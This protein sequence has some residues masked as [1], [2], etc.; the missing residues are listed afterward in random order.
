MK[1]FLGIDWTKDK[2]N[3]KINGNEFLVAALSED[4]AEDYENYSSEFEKTMKNSKLPMGLRV[5]QMICG[6]MA[7]IVFVGILRA[8]GGEDGLTL[9][10]AYESAAW[11]FWI[12]GACL[13]AWGILKYLSVRKEKT[14]MED[15]KEANVFSNFD[16]TCEAAFSELSVPDDAKEVDVLSFFYKVKENDIKLCQMAMQTC[17]YFN[18][19]FKAFS[20]EENLY[21]V[22]LDGKYAFPLSSLVAIRTVKVGITMSNWNKDTYFKE[23]IYKQYKIFCDGYERIHCKNYHILEVMHEGKLWGIYFPSYE[24]PAFE[25]LTGLKATNNK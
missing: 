4:T 15:A 7:A 11:V 1:P 16:K 3:T 20:D 5:G 12:G 14:V 6:T 22:N 2:K 25:A 13:A 10:Q 24:L 9:A 23:G 18:F 8:L 17:Q 19:A 21:L